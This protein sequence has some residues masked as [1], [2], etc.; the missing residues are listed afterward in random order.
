MGIF[1]VDTLLQLLFG[2]AMLVSVSYGTFP[3]AIIWGILLIVAYLD[4]LVTTIR[5]R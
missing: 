5:H 2:F 3:E 4:E 1:V